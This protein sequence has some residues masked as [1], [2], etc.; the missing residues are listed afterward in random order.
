MSSADNFSTTAFISA[1]EMPDR[2][3]VFIS[4]SWRT[5]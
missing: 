3:P 1:V 4:L 2:A 5:R